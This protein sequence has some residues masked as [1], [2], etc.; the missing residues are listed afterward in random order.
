MRC[1]KILGWLLAATMALSMVALSGIPD[2]HA[3]FRKR[4]K[5]LVKKAGKLVK[6]GKRYVRG[7][8]NTGKK[9]LKSLGKKF[10]DWG[11]KAVSWAKKKFAKSQ[12]LKKLFGFFK[13]NPVIKLFRKGKQVIRRLAKSAKEMV[14]KSRPSSRIP[15]FLKRLAA[16]RKARAKGGK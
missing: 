12:V 4:L 14:G 15:A 13:G 7:K 16:W 10:V 8:V 9:G 1:N 11:K 3:G 2:S 6:K 5:S